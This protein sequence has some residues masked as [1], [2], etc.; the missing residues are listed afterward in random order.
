M[1]M[2]QNVTLDQLAE[3]LRRRAAR[4]RQLTAVVGPPGA[5]KSTVAR[6]LH[7]RLNR[8]DPGS[9]A[10]I[11][12]DGFHLDNGILEERGWR[13]RKGAPHTF[14]TGGLHHIL[15]RLHENSEPEVAVPIFD[16]SREIAI[17]GA[18]LI[19]RTVRQLIVEGNYLLLDKSPWKEMGNCF[20]TTVFIDVSESELRRRLE[21]RW[22][23]LPHGDRAAKIEENDLPNARLVIQ[24]SRPA[25]FVLTGY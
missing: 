2:Q 8:Q 1:D 7:V 21:D 17:A 6:E 3:I 10:V 15:Q 19:P 16:R 23:G 5:G 9:T 14:D 12:M 13:G 18:R 25:E 22:R 11:P 20:D 24:H 4:E